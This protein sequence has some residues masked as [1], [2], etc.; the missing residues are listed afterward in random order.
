MKR[1]KTILWT[2]T[3][4]LSLNFSAQAQGWERAYLYNQFSNSVE[5]SNILEVDNQE[6][7]LTCFGGSGITLIKIDE[8]GDTIWVKKKEASSI[9][10][11]STASNNGIVY[12]TILA[13]ETRITE[14]DLNG[15]TR[16][17]QTYADPTIPGDIIQSID[18]GFLMVGQNSIQNTDSDS[19]RVTKFDATGNLLWKKNYFDSLPEKGRGIVELSDGNIMIA[20]VAGAFFDA[21]QSLVLLK[22]TPD[23]DVIWKNYYPD[24]DGSSNL[25]LLL[26]ANNDFVVKGTRSIIR[27]DDSGNLLWTK[28]FLFPTDI[29]ELSNGN[30]AITTNY[31]DTIT[32]EINIDFYNITAAGDEIWKRTYTKPLIEHF[33]PKINRTAD[34]GFL[35]GFTAAVGF[36]E[37]GAY[38]MV[39]KV[40]SLGELYTSQLSGK[41][42]NDEDDDCLNSPEETNMEGWIV[43]AS[44]S[45]NT[46]YGV[47]DEQGNYQIQIDTGNYTVSVLEL[48]EYWEP[49]MDSI[50]QEIMSRDTIDI[51]FP[52]QGI[53]DCPLLTVNIGTHNLVRCASNRYYVNYC[54]RGTIKA[55]DAYVEIDFDEDLQVDSASLMW[56]SVT[57]NTYT[58]NLGDLPINTCGNFHIYTTLDADCDATVLGETHCVKA[59]IYPDSFCLFDPA[60]DESSVEVDAFCDG[61][62]IRF[63]IANIGVAP[64]SEA[65]N[66]IVIEDNVMRQSSDFELGTGET[67]EVSFPSTGATLR[68]EAE[69]APGHPGVSRPNV[70]IEGCDPDGDGIFSLGYFT[71]WPNDDGSP[72]I[73]IECKENVDAYNINELDAF[74]RGVTEQHY[75]RQNTDHEY[76]IRFQN[77]GTGDAVTVVVLDTLSP[78]LDISTLQLGASSHPY[79]FEILTNHVLKFTFENIYLS[80]AA[81]DEADSQGFIK[82]RLRQVADNPIGTIIYN[83]AAIAFDRKAP[84][85][86]NKTYHEVGEDFIEI[87]LTNQQNLLPRELIKITPNPF[88]QM[89]LITILAEEGSDNYSLN[90]LNS[91]GQ[92][93][94]QDQFSGTQYIFERNDLG[95][96]L[97][98]FNIEKKH[99]IVATG[100]L[101]IP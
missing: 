98:I 36:P 100:K 24:Y 20:G 60:W 84:I 9:I 83:S 50:F 25:S 66:Y 101:I 88:N 6:H 89:T 94:R 48:Y 10:L 61:D 5:F 71:Q 41:I 82:F 75:V 81:V 78:F 13:E 28:D 57:G 34:A 33:F 53:V 16:W 74:P 67:K 64:M 40:N 12:T 19:I 65:L 93:V 68:L 85:L 49:C 73:S 70:T 59:H 52:M 31:R 91:L 51:D 29:I 23:G 18:N 42:W 55:E 11:G 72:H 77:T 30:F 32:N 37:P 22:L 1:M 63:Q 87:I 14:V 26:T 43:A 90:V 62:S 95:A 47:V 99:R 44:K 3:W 69:Q 39:Y 8:L 4:L 58:F 2:I 79:Q 86:T 27:F 45:E 15:N 7:I 54:N 21:D 80:P 35:I 46:F 92:M 56:S 38:P 17:S 76:Q 96:G 97:Y